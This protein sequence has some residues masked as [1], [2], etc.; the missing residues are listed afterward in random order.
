MAI[1]SV[2]GNASNTGWRT[3]QVYAMAVICLGVGL[4]LG[5][6]ARGSESGATKTA[7]A[8]TMPAVDAA[9]PPAA[10]KPM[11]SLDDMKQMADKQAAP[12]LEKLKTNPND[13]VVLNQVGAIFKMTHQFKAAEDYFQK[14]IQAD[15][16]NVGARTDLASCLYYEGDVDGALKQL[17]SAREA[18]PKDAS[19]LFNLGMIRWQGKG[20]ASGAV[21]IWEQL[22]KSNPK[23]A[24]DRKAQVEKLIAQAKEHSSGK[25]GAF[26]PM[27]ER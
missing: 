18:S 27:K 25:L 23:L 2:E 4:L 19:T 24:G 20:D 14:A 9:N 21:K 16:K 26:D 17:E 11:P 12:L 13:A 6:L 7:A 1:E 22:L 8:N 15:P 10:M 3:V 5:F